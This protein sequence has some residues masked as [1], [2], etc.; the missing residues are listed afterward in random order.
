MASKFIIKRG[1]ETELQSLTGLEDG[2][3]LYTTDTH[4]MYVA[5]GS[6]NV[7]DQV[8]GISYS[9]H[10]HN[11]TIG[12]EILPVSGSDNYIN[13]FFIK[14][15]SAKHLAYLSGWVGTLQTGSCT[16]S[17][18]QNN[19]NVVTD[20][21]IDNTVKSGSCNIS[22]NDYDML[23][24]EVSSSISASNLSFGLIVENICQ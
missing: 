14:L 1:T 18:K 24:I 8:V 19:S 15:D 9:S 22:L 12:G 17:I 11:Y 23:N 2:E 6:E 16:L 10:C 3:L 7:I 4:R 20:I 13:P 21:N 5:S